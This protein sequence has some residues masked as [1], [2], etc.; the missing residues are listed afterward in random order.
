MQLGSALQQPA[1]E[2]S[3]YEPLQSLVGLLAHSVQH[4]H[5]EGRVH[6][7]MVGTRWHTHVQRLHTMGDRPDL[8]VCQHGRVSTAW[9]CG[10]E[11]G[12][13]SQELASGVGMPPDAATSTPAS[14]PESTTPAALHA[15]EQMGLGIPARVDRCCLKYRRQ[16][17]MVLLGIHDLC[18]RDLGSRTPP[19]L[20]R[21]WTMTV[22]GC[23]SASLD[24]D[25]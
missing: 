1:L 4:I 8:G 6:W 7:G 14:L 10:Q 13:L 19:V 2:A 17:K 11:H 23:H 9:L 20:I 3:P 16:H 24:S 25:E 21:H 12:Q 22:P 18:I 15:L 5:A